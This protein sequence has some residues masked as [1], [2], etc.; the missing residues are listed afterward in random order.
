MKIRLFAIKVFYNNIKTLN[1]NNFLLVI[2]IDQIEKYM[3][4]TNLKNSKIQF[5]QFL[6]L[7]K[8]INSET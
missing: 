3:N 8:K 4:S 7:K 5:V 1:I 2:E 6:D